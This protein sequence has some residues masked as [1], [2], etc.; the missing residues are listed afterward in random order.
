[1]KGLSGERGR[2]TTIAVLCLEVLQG[3]TARF[4]EEKEKTTANGTVFV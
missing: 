1:M 2:V 3:S 4:S